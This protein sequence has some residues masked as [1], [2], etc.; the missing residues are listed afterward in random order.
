M[1]KER[2]F[3]LVKTNMAMKRNIMKLRSFHQL[4]LRLGDYFLCSSYLGRID[5]RS[6]QAHNHHIMKIRRGK[7]IGSI[8]GSGYTVS[9]TFD[10]WTAN[11]NKEMSEKISQ[12]EDMRYVRNA[13]WVLPMLIMS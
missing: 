9:A 2:L 12:Y 4:S 5:I 1:K 8:I 10:G 13:R 6:L 7:I 3:Y 11:F